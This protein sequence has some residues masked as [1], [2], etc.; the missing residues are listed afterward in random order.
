MDKKK[1]F[2]VGR[3]GTTGLRIDERL[4]G[5]Q[6]IE[7]LSIAEADRKNMDK[8]AEVA[9]QAD[10]IF[11]CLPD[12]AAKEVVEAVKDLSCKVID[13]STAHR[14]NPDWAYGF[15]ELGPEFRKGIEENRLIANPGCHA[16]GMVAILYPLVKAGLVPADYPV[17]ALSLTGYSGGGKK[18]IAQYEDDIQGTDL[19]SPRQYGLGQ[20]HKHL[21]EVTKIVGLAQAPI[22]QPI[23]DDYYSG[24]ETTIGFHTAFLGKPVTAKDM[25]E[26][27]N[28][29]YQGSKMVKVAPFDLE[30][31][32]KTILA[33]NEASGLDTM[34]LYVSGND[35][36]VLVH[37]IFDNLGKGASGSAVQCMN[38]ALGLPEETGLSL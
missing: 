9:A 26:A 19:Y 1:V 15:A 27:L 32:N 2:I 16:S 5:R 4:S 10:V 12:A 34:T 33:A 23:V 3:E 24:M 20:A 25:W 38:I 31:T 37:A 28:K 13:A 6:D 11:L 29:H 21:P 22:F 30:A 35:D 14:T 18:M 17:S 36:R 7:L 8:I